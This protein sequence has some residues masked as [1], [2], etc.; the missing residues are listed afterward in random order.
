MFKNV[1][2]GVDGSPNGR[3]AVALGS[4]LAA[5][6]GKLTL[7]HVRPGRLHT[8]HAV[9]TGLLKEERR[10]SEQL[11]ERELALTQVCADLISIVSTS[12]GRGLHE[13]AEDLKADLLVVGSC[14]HGVFGRAI[15]GDDTRAALNGAPCAVAIAAHGYSEHPT[16]IAKIGVGYNGSRE[17]E[18]ALEFARTLAVRTRAAVE[19]V[20]IISMPTYGFVDPA[21]GESMELMLTAA[22][23]RMKELPGV[24]GRAVYGDAGERLAALGDDVDLLVVGSRS[25]GAVLRLVLGSTCDYLER[26]ARCSLLVLP[27]LAIGRAI[28]GEDDANTTRVAA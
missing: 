16:P 3:D 2:I 1:L 21:V 7:A 4:R 9:T 14:G 17:S 15:L 5:R 24:A 28:N 22:S 11:L 27:R 6:E 20:E 26:H 10:A 12:P 25:H 19:A 18:A 13:C 23:N 8:F